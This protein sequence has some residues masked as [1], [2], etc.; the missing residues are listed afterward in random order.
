MYAGLNKEEKEALLEVTKMGF[1]PQS[2]FGYRTM[3]IHGFMVLYQGVVIADRTYFTADFW[4]VPGYLGA[5]PP[6]SLLKARIQ[7]VSRIKAGI[8]L[9]EAVKWGIAEAISDNVRGTAGLAWKSIGG[10]EGAMPVAFQLEDEMPE[11]HFL[12]GDLVIRSGAAAGKTLQL[13]KVKGDKVVLGPV[14]PSVLILINHGDEV[15]VDNS[16]FLAVQ[17][18]HRHQVPGKEY[19]VWDQFRD[20]DGNPL[21]PQ[22]PMLLGPIFTRA[23]SGTVPA[24]KFK[25]K[26]I[27]LSSL[28]DR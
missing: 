6:A 3:G 12:G 19:P 4:N 20:A 13:T 9:H 10:K 11:V 5:N 27:V 7:K 25:G 14:D 18:Y 22:R 17:T 28:W 8:P 1:P 2:W 26:M 24:G 23:A 16:N 15:Q 21:Y